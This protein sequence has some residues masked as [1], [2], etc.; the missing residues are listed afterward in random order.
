MWAT[1]FRKRDI[2]AKK[3]RQRRDIYANSHK[4]LKIH[5]KFK[6]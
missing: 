2:Y 1:S 3:E 4:M 5:L 6:I